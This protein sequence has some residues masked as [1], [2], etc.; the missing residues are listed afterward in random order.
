MIWWICIGAVA[1]LFLNVVRSLPLISEILMIG[2][3]DDLMRLQQV[4]DWLAGQGWFDTQQYQILPPE[5]ISMH[6]S[7]YVDLGIAAFLVPAS[8]LL[9]PAQAELAAVILWPTFL[10]C[11]MLL[12]IGHANNRLMGLGAAIGGLVAFLTWGK[13]GGEFAAGRID[14]HNVQILTA[15][16]I[17][18]LSV[19]PGRPQILG[20]MAGALTAFSLAVG[21]EMLPFLAVIW[22]MMVLRQAVAEEGAGTW[23]IGFCVAFAVAAPVL[24]A[25]QTAVPNWSIPYCDVLAPPI[26][27]LAAIGI[28]ATLA[29]VFLAGTIRHPVARIILSLAI[30]AAGLWLAA[31]LLGPCLA[32]PYAD[33]APEVRTIIETQVTEA[34]S[35]S[36][37][38]QTRPELFFRIMMPAVV[39]GVLALAAAWYLRAGISRSLGIALIQSFVV[40][41]VGIAFALVQIRAANLMTP[42]VP[43]LAGF[44]VHAFARIPGT[45]RLRIPAVV[46]LLLA[47][48]AVVEALSRKVAGPASVSA[49]VGESVARAG[50]A[51]SVSIAYCR[52]E[53]AMEEIASLP[54]SVVFS[55]MNLGPAIVVYTQHSATS[56]GY[57]R[58]TAAYTNGVFAFQNRNNLHRAL[59]SSRADYLVVCVGAGEERAITRLEAE[60]WPD[61]LQDVTGD[62]REVRAFRIDKVALASDLG[63]P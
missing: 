33:A 29:P 12:V 24:L 26:L 62:R 47:T 32:G 63:G 2:D 45:S 7:R 44:L 23:L 1:I 61:W 58:S 54:K 34:L 16:A 56:A 9:P 36:I 31:P 39:I 43:L 20:A 13:L 48:P 22:G 21:L 38:L 35:A 50:L 6:W 41:V 10:G 28:V 60:G 52:T 59:S 49:M 51:D 42:V 4:R 18:Y 37:L 55:S 19:M 46:I 3:V 30:V 8:W 25:G 57:H 40:L 15:T 17:F 14:H 5:G 11:L 53:G 27:A